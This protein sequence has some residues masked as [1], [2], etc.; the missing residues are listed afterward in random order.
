MAARQRKSS[1]ELAVTEKWFEFRAGLIEHAA[2][3]GTEVE[4]A[5]PER[6]TLLVRSAR[7]A[8]TRVVVRLVA[9]DRDVRQTATLVYRGSELN[10]CDALICLDCD[11]D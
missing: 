10:Y 1:K 9:H 4:A 11:A 7:S 2:K 8:I 5:G 6:I 3:L